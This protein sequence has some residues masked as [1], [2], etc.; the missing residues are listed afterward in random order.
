MEPPAAIRDLLSHVG[1]RGQLCGWSYSFV[2]SERTHVTVR[3]TSGRLQMSD[4]AT[5]TIVTVLGE[6]APEAL[7]PTIMHEHLFIDLSTTFTPVADPDLA[8]FREMPVG[9]EM[10]ELLH[11]WPFSL[12]VDNGRLLD[13]KVA[14]EELAQF[15]NAGGSALVDCTLEGIGRDPLAVRRVAEATGLHVIQGTGYYVELTHPA[16]VRSATVEQLAAHFVREL[17]DGIGE[18]GVRAGIIGEIGVSGI[19]PAT[20]KIEG[21]ITS[22]EEKVLRAAGAASIETGAAVTVHLDPRSTGADRVI[23]ILEEEGV[24]PT[25]MIMGH[26]DANPN[27]EYHLRVADR[28][29][30]VEYDHFGREYYAGHMNQP[31][32]KDARRVELLLELLRRGFER[33]L[34]L[35]QDV[36]AKIDLERF[37]GNGY[38]HVLKRIVPLL[39]GEG[40]GEDALDAMLVENPRRALAF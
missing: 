37:G 34:L 29:V 13:E 17:R 25:R 12:T 20:R 28:G 14:V 26:M 8:R 10:I 38:G 21:V 18:T 6:I 33:Q 40:V 3:V 7:G 9:P 16:H 2:V 5:A 11:Q 36:C 15:M 22:E 1:A 39:R 23:D 27:V 31:Y 32:T 24:D 19:N 30:F 4:E 35:S